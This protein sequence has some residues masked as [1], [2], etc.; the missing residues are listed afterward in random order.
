MKKLKT[1]LLCS[2]VILG[3][4]YFTIVIIKDNPSNFPLNYQTIEGKIKQIII[5]G[6][7]LQVTLDSKSGTIQG[8]YTISSEEEKNN[9]LKWQLGD[10]IEVKGEV[11]IP[12]DSTIF[13][14]FSYRH[15]LYSKKIYHTISI[16]TIEKRKDNQNFLYHLKNWILKQLQKSQNEKYL[17]TFLLGDKSL[18]EESMIESYQ[19]NGVSHLFAVSG[20]HISLFVAILSWLLQKIKC[21]H[22]LLSIFFCFYAFL[23]GFT[24]SIVR[25]TTLFIFS[26][27]KYKPIW[28]LLILSFVLIL[29]NPFIIYDTGFLFSFIISGYLLFFGKKMERIQN[30]IFRLW[31]TSFFCFLVSIPISII[32][33][34]EVYWLSSIFNILF[35][36]FVSYLVFPLTILT[37]V[38]PFL[39]GLL[40]IVISLMEQL[41]LFC[42][43]FSISTSMYSISFVIFLLYYLVITLTFMKPKMGIGLS[44]L[45]TVHIFYKYLD[46]NTY[47]TMLDVGQ[48]DSVL[49]ELSN[50]RNIL[51][52]TG[53]ILNYEKEDWQVRKKETNIAKNKIIPYLKSRGIGKLEALVLTH[54]DVD[55]LGEAMH[56]LERFKVKQVIMNSGNNNAFENKIIEYCNKHNISYQQISRK[57]VKI[58]NQTFSLLNDKDSQNEN[59]DSLVFYTELRGKNILFMGDAGEES[60]E[61]IL[62]NYQL[63]KIDI[64]KVGHHGSRN[65][66]SQGFIDAIKPKYSIIGVGKN[67]RYKHPHKETLEV[68]TDSQIYRTDIHGSIQIKFDKN[69]YKIRTC[70]P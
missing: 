17:R 39:D 38:L 14:G 67:N 59:E 61:E 37:F 20:M 62:K 53:G 34:H 56:L 22:W 10:V 23:T 43:I 24:P 57:T 13:N 7:S 45:L 46:S 16:E 21:R 55:H 15:Y 51:V 58:A 28:I 36:P 63:P 29:Y 5:D 42:N 9:L 64:L 66:S 69:G 50:N 54:G 49:M 35:V 48:G 18:L 32:S 6:D 40:G 70:N 26:S 27:S 8:F 60:E 33:F 52:D 31:M 65:S 44:L 12:N 4:L 3:I 68:L 47:I 25:A 19:K 1:S 30:P 2:V 41:S 11:E